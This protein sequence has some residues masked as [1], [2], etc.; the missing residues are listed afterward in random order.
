MLQRFRI[1]NNMNNMNMANI[2]PLDVM[3]IMNI[4]NIKPSNVMNNRNWM[5]IKP[6]DIM[7]N[8]N[9]VNVR[10]MNNLN[11]AN[12]EPL[13]V[14]NTM[15]LTNVKP[16]DIMNNLNMANIVLL[17]MMNN[18]NMANIELFDIMNN[19]NMA[20]IELLDIMNNMNMPN[21]ELLD[22]MNNMNVANFCECDMPKPC[23]LSPRGTQTHG[24][25]V[26]S[27]PQFHLPS[28]GVQKGKTSMADHPALLRSALALALRLCRTRILGA[29]GDSRNGRRAE[30]SSNRDRAVGRIGTN[31]HIHP[32]EH[33]HMMCDKHRQEGKCPALIAC[34]MGQLLRLFV[35]VKL[36]LL[37][38]NTRTPA[39]AC[40]A[41]AHIH[42]TNI[43]YDP[44]STRMSNTNTSSTIN[45][46]CDLWFRFTLNGLRGPGHD[47]SVLTVDETWLSPQNMTA[48]STPSGMLSSQPH[49]LA[50]DL[51]G[52]GRTWEQGQQRAPGSI[53]AIDRYPHLPQYITGG[54][55]L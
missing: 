21:N 52:L 50:L 19:L 22:V 35:A 14:M 42:V 29:A 18:M 55:T 20:N 53:L 6:L 7:N 17:D 16:L 32:P 39:R 30:G 34:H 44:H 23:G 37:H 47:R 46:S 36:G 31:Q 45:S 3:N 8:L 49:T 10:V 40:A 26:H 43:M 5:N 48:G 9:M 15:N 12:I 1:L 51:R 41:H 2:E 27:L 11:M 4:A 28:R 54:N 33:P 25:L 13:D 38:L 24:D